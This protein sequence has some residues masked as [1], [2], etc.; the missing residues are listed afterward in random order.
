MYL[1]SETELLIM[2][3]IVTLHIFKREN[4]QKFKQEKLCL[5]ERKTK[6][7]TGDGQALDKGPREAV[8]SPP[9]GIFKTQIDKTLSS[10]L[11]L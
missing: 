6:I 8:E 9:L 7:H 11:V 5:H 4:S 2:D 3:K 1:Y 10:S